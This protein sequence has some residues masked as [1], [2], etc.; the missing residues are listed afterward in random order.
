LNF[1]PD[2]KAIAAPPFRAMVGKASE[3]PSPSE[4]ADAARTFRSKIHKRRFQCLKRAEEAIDFLP[5]EGE[6]LHTTM[7]GYYDLMHL[8]IVCLRR[9]AC[10]AATLRIMTLSLSA[11]NVQEMVALYD[12]GDAQRIDVVAANYFQKIEADIFAELVA[13]FS[14]RGQRVGICRS[15]AKIIT[16]ALTDGRKYTIETSANLRS[17]R[18]REAFTLFR[19]PHLFDFRDREIEEAVIRYAVN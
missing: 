16:I 6:A 7:T 11:R 3:A 19:C 17:N 8:L 18:N 14:K 4:H 15:H 2:F 9:F 13:E 1:G 10:P 5:E 12:N